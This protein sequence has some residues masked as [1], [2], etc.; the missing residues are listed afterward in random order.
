[1]YSGDRPESR[2]SRT[3]LKTYSVAWSDWVARLYIQRKNCQEKSGVG[4][5]DGYSSSKDTDLRARFLRF[6]EPAV[7]FYNKLPLAPFTPERLSSTP[8]PYSRPISVTFASSQSGCTKKHWGIPIS[9]YSSVA[10]YW[11]LDIALRPN[12]GLTY[13]GGWSSR[14]SKLIWLN[15]L[16]KTSHSCEL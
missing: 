6:A 16:K 3:S 9:W 5:H 12:S 1:M 8:M 11:E 14:N 4:N 15:C 13:S 7:L 2:L 10:S